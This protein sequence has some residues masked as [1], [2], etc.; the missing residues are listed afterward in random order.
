[1]GWQAVHSNALTETGRLSVQHRSVGKDAVVQTSTVTQAPDPDAV[2]VS[3][4]MLA[5]HRFG[6]RTGS[7]A[8][9]DTGPGKPG[10]RPHSQN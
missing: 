5:R 4:E 8:R 1:M 2:V 10:R 7:R 6:P 9:E 3:F